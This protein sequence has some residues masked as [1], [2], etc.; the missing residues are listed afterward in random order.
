MLAIAQTK[1]YW[2]KQVTFMPDR[3]TTHKIPWNTKS[4]NVCAVIN[5][6]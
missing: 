1:V 5:I 6:L 4:L 3:M 2:D